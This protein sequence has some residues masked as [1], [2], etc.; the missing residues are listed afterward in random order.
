[1]KKH[2][3]ALFAL[4]VLAL[5]GC[6]SS[7]PDKPIDASMFE[8][9]LA[10]DASIDGSTP[11]RLG[12]F[13]PTCTGT[14]LPHVVSGVQTSACSLVVQTT[15]VTGVLPMA[16]GGTNVSALAAANGVVTSSGTAL[17]Q[18]TGVLAGTNFVSV[19]AAPAAAAALRLP[20][21]G[22]AYARNNGNTADLSVFE[23][24]NTDSVWIGSSSAATKQFTNI[25]LYNASSGN[26]AFGAGGATEFA[27]RGATGFVESGLPITGGSGYASSSPYGVHGVGSVALP[28]GVNATTTLVAAVYKNFTIQTTAA[29]TANQNI[30]LPTATDA[31]A[32]TKVINNICTGAFSVIVQCT[33]G[34]FVTIANGK[35]AMV[36]VDSRGV[37]RL[38]PDT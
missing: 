13:N 1:M 12:S 23:T 2:L 31:T 37:T 17:Q 29:L 15:D 19:G 14:G 7:A 21:P 4:L 27:I 20:S 9:C 6:P 33:A 11:H 5:V 25:Y 36:L 26:V 3:F 18:A 24:D 35:S 34:A 30:V 32:Y 22:N 28:T 38:T 10:L 8:P 16:N